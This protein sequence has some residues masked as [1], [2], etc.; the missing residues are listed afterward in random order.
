MKW[1]LKNKCKF[2]LGYILLVTAILFKNLK[3]VIRYTKTRISAIMYPNQ[4]FKKNRKGQKIGRV[5]SNFLWPSRS[6]AIVLIL[7][8]LRKPRNLTK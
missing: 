7:F 5:F 1:D 4:K 3:D 2:E 6:K 8:N